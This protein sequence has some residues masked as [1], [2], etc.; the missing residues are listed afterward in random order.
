MH[1]FRILHFYLNPTFQIAQNHQEYPNQLFTI[2][3]IIIKFTHQYSKQTWL[4]VTSI[5]GWKVN[6]YENFKIYALQI[7]IPLISSCNF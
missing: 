7:N 4:S 1:A 3:I 6:S 2:I 5:I